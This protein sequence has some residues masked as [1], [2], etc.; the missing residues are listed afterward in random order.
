M[1]GKKKREVVKDQEEIKQIQKDEN[2]EK[3]KMNEQLYFELTGKR[4][5][6]VK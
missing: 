2:A 6:E 1:F 3:D 5:E 4:R